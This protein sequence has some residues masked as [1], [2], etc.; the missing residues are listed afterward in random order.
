MKERSTEV[1]PFDRPPKALGD[2]C[3]LGGKNVFV[4]NR[5]PLRDSAPPPFDEAQGAPSDVEGRGP[6]WANQHR[7]GSALA[8][9]RTPPVATL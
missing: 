8:S 1:S 5:G 6:W 3:V 4:T 9:I 7:P 2:L